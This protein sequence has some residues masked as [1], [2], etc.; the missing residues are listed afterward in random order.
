MKDKIK[1][2]LSKILLVAFVFSFL[3]IGFISIFGTEIIAEPEEAIQKEEQISERERQIEEVKS[4]EDFQRQQNL[5]AEK[6]YL[7][8]KKEELIREHELQIENIENDLEK[9]REKMVDFQ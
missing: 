7:E 9:V 8:E 2:I 1:N 3:G 5:E 4:R 6:I